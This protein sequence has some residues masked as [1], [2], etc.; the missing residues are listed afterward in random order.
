MRIKKL[1]LLLL[2]FPFICGFTSIAHRG[3][4]Q[5]GKYAEHSFLAYDHALADQSDYL[6]LDLQKTADNIL[7]VSHDDNLSRVFGVNKD[8]AKSKFK[9][10]KKYHNRSD[11]PIHS[12]QEVFSR[13][14]TDPKVKFM[15]ETKKDDSSAGMEKDLV[16]LIKKNYLQKR[17]LFESFSIS[18]LALLKKLAPNIP[19]TQLGGDYH[20]IGN[21]QF[22]SNGFYDKKT[23]KYLAQHEKGYIIWGVD[24]TSAIKKMKNDGNVTGIMTDYSNRLEKIAEVNLLLPVRLIMGKAFVKK[25]FAIVQNS[26]Q[27]LPQ[28]T[29]LKLKSLVLQN[30]KLMYGLGQGCFISASDLYKVNKKAPKTKVGLLY[31]KKKAIVWKDPEGKENSGRVLRAN[32]KWNYFAV[33]NVSGHDFYN[34]GGNQWIDGKMVK[35]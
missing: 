28:N 18:S 5:L 33:S 14:H 8:I 34:L 7:V 15:I 1:A 3:E 6:E 11:E 21:S 35:K 13:Y 23:A 31:L 25:P 29:P 19:R 27:I 30:G 10:L 16:K 17:V 24:K 9:D 4:N 22:Y 20:N 26:K 12:L 2:F 32:S